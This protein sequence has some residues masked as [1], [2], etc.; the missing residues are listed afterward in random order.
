[1]AARTKFE[2]KFMKDKKYCK[3]RDHYDYGKE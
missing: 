1:M 2:N 3:V